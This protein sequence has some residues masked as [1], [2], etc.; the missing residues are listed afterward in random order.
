MNISMK[1]D[2]FDGHSVKARDDREA[3]A[4]HVILNGLRSKLALEGSVDDD[5]PSDAEAMEA[6][7]NGSGTERSGPN[8]FRRAA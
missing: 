5:G 1:I 8:R 7:E 3:A 2:A 4:M 6:M